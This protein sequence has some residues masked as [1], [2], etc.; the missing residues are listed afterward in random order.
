MYVKKKIPLS[1]II[2]CQLNPV[3][4]S[5][6]IYRVRVV[7]MGQMGNIIGAGRL[8]LQQIIYM[9]NSEALIV[10]YLLYT[11]YLS[12]IFYRPATH[13]D[14]ICI[15]R[16]FTLRIWQNTDFLPQNLAK[17][18]FFQECETFFFIFSL[19]IQIFS[20]EYWFS[21]SFILI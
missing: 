20:I 6:Y 14:F 13:T 4:I 3:S 10:I 19:V 12:F 15:Y 18:R 2:K 8:F 21:L 7:K 1:F 9:I 11:E 16:F 17:Y 5:M